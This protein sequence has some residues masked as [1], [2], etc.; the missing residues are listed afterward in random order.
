VTS[1]LVYGA[2]SASRSNPENVKS[3]S[4]GSGRVMSRTQAKKALAGRDLKAEMKERGVEL[5]GGALDEAPDVYKPIDE[6]MRYQE[7][8][9]DTLAE[10][11]PLLVRMADD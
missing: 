11:H 10:F 1:G 2:Y 4:H 6:V 5:I 8:L 7:H 3:A 9:V